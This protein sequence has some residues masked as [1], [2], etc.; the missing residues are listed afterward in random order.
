MAYYR[1]KDLA[2]RYSLAAKDDKTYVGVHLIISWIHDELS[3]RG[4]NV[5]SD[6]LSFNPEDIGDMPILRDTLTERLAGIGEDRL[7]PHLAVALIEFF[8]N[9][10]VRSPDV[11]SMAI[12][13]RLF[14]EAIFKRL[15]MEVEDE[16]CLLDVRNRVDVGDLTSTF[17][18]MLIVPLS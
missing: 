11:L 7:N 4:R 12:E 8:I 6:P 2:C 5:P 1:L 16:G 15:W 14:L 10:H 17:L 9:Y 13:S 18:R 3:A